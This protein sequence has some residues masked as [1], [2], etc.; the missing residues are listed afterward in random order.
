MKYHDTDKQQKKNPSLEHR[1][2]KPLGKPG[3]NKLKHGND[4]GGTSKG[5]LPKTGFSPKHTL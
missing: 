2:E 4:S 5:T 3:R 1:S